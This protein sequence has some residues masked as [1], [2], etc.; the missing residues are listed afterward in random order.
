[1]IFILDKILKSPNTLEKQTQC[2]SIWL[3]LTS[4]NNTGQSQKQTNPTTLNTN[5]FSPEQVILWKDAVHPAKLQYLSQIP[6]LA[7][8]LLTWNCDCDAPSANCPFLALKASCECNPPLHAYADG[9]NVQDSAVM[10]GLKDLDCT[11]W[12]KCS[13]WVIYHPGSQQTCTVGEGMAS[14]L[15]LG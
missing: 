9:Y 3:S 14:Q 8:R 1:M 7:Q 11:W 6:I 15:S 5:C 13:P 12:D 4:I 2:F 10:G